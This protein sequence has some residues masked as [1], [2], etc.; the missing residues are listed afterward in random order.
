M[1]KVCIHVALLTHMKFKNKKEFGFPKLI[2][3]KQLEFCLLV[4]IFIC[5]LL[6][7]TPPYQGSYTRSTMY[8]DMG[9]FIDYVDMVI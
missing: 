2:T 3:L 4:F 8:N 6:V 7:V 5:L 9:F 1:I